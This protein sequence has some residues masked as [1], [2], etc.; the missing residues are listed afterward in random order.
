M[1]SVSWV[2]VV[3]AGPCEGEDDDE[4]CC[5]CCPVEGEGSVAAIP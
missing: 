2:S 1:L 4:H 3:V 5:C